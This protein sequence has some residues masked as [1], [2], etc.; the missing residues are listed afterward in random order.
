MEKEKKKSFETFPLVKYSGVEP[1]WN[2]EFKK[3]VFGRKHLKTL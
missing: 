2:K 3:S 1:T